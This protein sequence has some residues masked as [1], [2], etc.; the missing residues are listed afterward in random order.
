VIE[1]LAIERDPDRAILV[2]E[3]LLPELEVDHGKPRMHKRHRA[4]EHPTRSI[5]SPVG[6]R[7]EHAAQLVARRRRRS[8]ARDESG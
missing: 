2:R 3:R 5:G 7:S 8:T 1:D 4:V 6:D